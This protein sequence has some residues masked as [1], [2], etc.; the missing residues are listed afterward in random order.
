M[1]YFNGTD[2]PENVVGGYEIDSIYG[3]GGN[4]TLAGGFAT[5][6]LYGGLGNDLLSG[7]YQDDYLYG[8]DGN[9]RLF[10]GSGDDYFSGG[11]G[12]DYMDGGTG[13]DRFSQSWLADVVGD[14]LIGGGGMDELELEFDGAGAGVVFTATDPLVTARIAGF[15]YVGI[16]MFDID[17][18][19]YGDRF[20]G[21]VYND[22]F[23]GGGGNDTMFGGL[24]I[25][26]LTGDDGND[27]LYG[28]GDDDY[29]SGGAGF[30]YLSGDGGDDDLVGGSEND[31]LLGGTGNDDL[32]GNSGADRLDGGTGNDTLTSDSYLSDDGRERDTLSGGDGQDWLAFGQ[33][34]IVNAGSGFDRV[35]VDFS[36]STFNERWTFSPAA[37]TFNNGAYLVNAE[38]L[39]YD[40][41]SGVDEITGNVQADTLRG[42]GGSDTLNG[43]GG[44][45]SLDGGAGNDVLLGLDGDDSFYSDSGHDKLFGNAGN[46]RFMIGFDENVLLPYS[47]TIDGGAGRD[48]VDF[49]SGTLGAVVDL[50]AQANNA[51]LAYGK[52]ISNVEA[53]D[54]TYHDDSFA[55]TQFGD[56][57]RG[58]GGDDVLVGRGGNDRLAGNAGSDI[59]VG[60][61]GA[62]VFDF[63]DYYGSDW[64]ADTITDFTR[65]QDKLLF[66][67]DAL[68]G[69][70]LRLVNS[71]NP[72]ATTAA[73]TLT[74]ETDTGRL[75]F[76][77]D[78]ALDRESP[79]LL[80]TL[81]GVG[82]LA[83]S[84][85]ALV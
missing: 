72:L 2:A 61:A 69:A 65:G 34:D 66:D 50:I 21:W 14:T 36:S 42:G 4:D 83:W 39:S 27:S 79:D 6:Y 31:I 75:W 23:A 8:E 47:V 70:G 63:L 22:T 40:G 13:D 17:G 55:G 51:G 10:G 24:G 84:D 77:A 53:L 73:P 20:A 59:L 35:T 26:Y 33:N 3:N 19:L 28:G 1:G 80:M 48:E 78:G 81:N 76:D 18:S 68:G 32:E 56:A 29:V 5:D 54:G 16:E 52:R 11:A 45:D 41:G 64:M 38:V 49:T 37:K 74:F 58:D 15:T 7:G 43:A 25:D 46:D 60:G 30:D 44:D 62:D 9:D 12:R 57:L 71:A 85:F 67:Q 82:A